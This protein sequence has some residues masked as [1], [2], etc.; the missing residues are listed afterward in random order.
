MRGERTTRIGIVETILEF[1]SIDSV[2]MKIIFVGCI[3]RFP[4]GGHAW[5]DLHYLLGLRALGHELIYLEDCG[6]ES[7]VY[8]WETEEID[9]SLDYPAHYIQA[10]LEPWGLG[11]RWTYRSS[12][13]W[14]GLSPT[15]VAAACSEADLMI[16]RA[17][18][19]PIWRP[20][21]LR[22]R[23][24]IFIDGDPGF[25]QVKAL[26]GDLI[27]LQTL[28]CC[29][30]LFSVGLNIGSPSWPIPTGGHLWNPT[31]PP[32][33]LESWPAVMQPTGEEFLAVLQWRSYAPLRFEDLELGNKDLT[34]PGY[35]DLPRIAGVPF[36][37]ALSGGDP[38]LLESHGWSV[39]EGWSAT[40]LPSDYRNLIAS[41]RA[42]FAVAK[43]GYVATHSAWF[44]D[45]TAAFL[46][47]GLP[48]LIQDT[49]LGSHFQ[50]GEGLLAFSTFDEAVAGVAE[51][52]RH[53]YDHCQSARAFAEQ[54]LDS[55]VVLTDLL[56]RS[57]I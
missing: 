23:R 36:K 42:E 6:E 31:M 21:Y 29:H 25:T 11:E 32:I 4:I 8:N 14:R 9:H 19:M 22:T 47:A 55:A 13:G 37:L 7:W 33:H 51:I 20:E 49:G 5:A 16:L 12:G 53:Y 50:L 46:A 45:R 48:A 57:M 35:I 1:K 2:L 56:D 52:N 28:D 38:A 17:V 15:A 30:H 26:Q 44:S 24:R 27:L 10:C 43:S 18:P 39:C 54:H 3:G 41:S 40:F 34:F